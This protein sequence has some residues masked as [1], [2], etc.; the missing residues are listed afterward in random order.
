MEMADGC[1]LVDAF[2]LLGTNL[3]SAEKISSYVI[4]LS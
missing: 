2:P 1:S 4:S 3:A